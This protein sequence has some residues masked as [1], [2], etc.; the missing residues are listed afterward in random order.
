MEQKNEYIVKMTIEELSETS[1]AIE[2]R[3]GELLKDLL[4]ADGYPKLKE[5]IEY[6]IKHLQTAMD[7]INEATWEYLWE[8][9][10]ETQGTTD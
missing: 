9:Q 3:L 4:G 8:G 2:I 7:K 1:N 6:K 10:N 5:Y